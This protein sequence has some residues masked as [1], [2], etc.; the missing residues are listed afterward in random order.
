MIRKLLAVAA[1]CSVPACG[2]SISAS[3]PLTYVA[4]LE[5]TWTSE[6]DANVE[7]RMSVAGGQ[8]LYETQFD[9]TAELDDGGGTTSYDGTADGDAITLRDPGSGAVVLTGTIEDNTMLRLE[10]GRTFTKPFEPEL[11]GVWQDVNYP[12]RY[13]IVTAQSN[14]L[15][16]GCAVSNSPDLRAQDA[17][18][19]LDIAFAGVDISL[20]RV[21]D[22]SGLLTVRAPAFFV[23]YSSIRVKR[24]D[25]Y[26][27]LQR[28]DEPVSCPL[29]PGG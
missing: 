17:E 16:S 6:T 22:D 19:D 13:Y 18:G 9:F 1:L 21:I 7:F 27:H 25:G 8:P 11:V 26:I 23:G 14:N 15:A 10:D 3:E 29:V 4:P 20:W 24:I 2:I 5:G 12:E 28:V